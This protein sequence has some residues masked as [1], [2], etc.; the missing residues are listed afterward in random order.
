M[1]LLLKFFCVTLLQFLCTTNTEAASLWSN[2]VGGGGGIQYS[3]KELEVM[4]EVKSR[5][6]KEHK[7]SYINPRFLAYTVIVSDSRVDTATAKYKKFLDAVKPF[8]MDIVESDKDMYKDPNVANFI[9]DRYQSCGVDK[10]GHQVM[11]IKSAST[12]KKLEKTSVRAGI[13]YTVAAHADNKSLREGIT[14]VIDKSTTNGEEE[15]I[16]NEAKLQ[17]LSQA[18]PLNPNA[19]LIAGASA[20]ARVA[21]NSLIGVGSFFS[22]DKVLQ[23]IKFVSV[24]TAM[25]KISKQNA[26]KYLG[27]GGGNIKDAAAWARKRYESLPIPAL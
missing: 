14:F 10:G 26:P 3:D 25:E 18:Y 27:G 17:Q 9:R 24:D 22:K 5:L 23:S 2:T 13:M 8:G 7:V 15:K 12:P 6:E 4:R 16:G 20:A 19:F 11:W 1:T 21:I